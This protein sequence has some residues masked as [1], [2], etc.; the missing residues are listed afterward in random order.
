[1]ISTQIN[2]LTHAEHEGWCNFSLLNE[3]LDLRLL[4]CAFLLQKLLLPLSEELLKLVLGL[5]G[6]NAGCV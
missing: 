6:L 5:A 3:S 1:M 4:L 2:W